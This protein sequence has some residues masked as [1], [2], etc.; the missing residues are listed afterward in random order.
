[1]YL[2]SLGV[3]SYEERVPLQLMDF[4]YRYTT[5]VLA[6][7]L[8]VDVPIETSAGG[9]GGGGGKG[10]S[11]KTGPHAD[12]AKNDPRADDRIGMYALKQAIGSRVGYA[13]NT[14]LP[15]DFLSE[16]ATSV[17]K[18]S[19]PKMEREWGIRLPSEKYV[20]TGTGWGIKEEWEEEGEE[21]EDAVMAE[22][23]AGN[24]AK[25]TEKE[26]VE[27]EEDDEQGFEDVFGKQPTDSGAM[28]M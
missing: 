1:M 5:G 15:K 16:L 3:H 22:A 21:R 20:L 8:A 6:D 7:V 4:A 11:H 23:A 18:V 14:S 12:P 28:E 27:M 10:S 17:N 2:A 24:A 25:E 9:A 19:L 13:F 26:D